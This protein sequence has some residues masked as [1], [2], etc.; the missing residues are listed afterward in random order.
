M[1]YPRA[2]YA[3]CDGRGIQS[4]AKVSGKAPHVSTAYARYP[5]LARSIRF[6]AAAQ[7]APP[8]FQ[9]FSLPKVSLY[10]G[11]AFFDVGQEVVF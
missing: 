1:P 11:N 2:Y 6:W 9:D 10:Q 7:S 5:Q 4:L 8:A 3:V